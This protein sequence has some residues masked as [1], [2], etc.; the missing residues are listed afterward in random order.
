VIEQ[1]ARADPLGIAALALLITYV[2]VREVVVPKAKAESSPENDGLKHPFYCQAG[3]FDS[4][5]AKLEARCTANDMNFS[6]LEHKID[7]VDAKLNQ[8]ISHVAGIR[9]DVSWVRDAVRWIKAD[10]EN[11]GK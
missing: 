11:G 4:R 9:A 1:L 10:R 3:K 5:I 6:K 8:S 2:L 7:Q